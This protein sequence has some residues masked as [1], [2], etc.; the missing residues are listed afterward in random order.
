MICFIIHFDLY[1]HQQ[2]QIIFHFDLLTLF[3]ILTT[4]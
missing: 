1:L 3:D 4:F 2:K